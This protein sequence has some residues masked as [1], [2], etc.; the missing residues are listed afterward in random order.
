MQFL[1][2]LENYERKSSRHI[3]ASKSIQDTKD[4]IKIIA[5]VNFGN[6]SDEDL[7]SQLLRETKCKNRL[8]LQR[9]ERMKVKK[10]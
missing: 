10:F 5:I 3:K 2:M 7:T 4:Y 8:I 9:K 1:K 6:R